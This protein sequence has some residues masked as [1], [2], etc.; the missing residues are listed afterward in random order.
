MGDGQVRKNASFF[1][2]CF[3]LCL[4]RACL[5]KTFVFTHKWL[6]KEKMPSSFCQDSLG[7]DR[8]RRERRSTQKENCGGVL[9]IIIVIIVIIIIILIIVI[10]ITIIIIIV[11]I[12]RALRRLHRPLRGKIERISSRNHYPP[13]VLS[14]SSPPPDKT[15]NLRYLPRDKTINL[16]YL[17][18]NPPLSLRRSSTPSISIIR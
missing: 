12:G 7:T 10:I 8:H 16:R 11:I 5:G 15:I 18:M 6:K 3:S 17:A 4:S 9:I 1:E 14:Q 2:C 13:P